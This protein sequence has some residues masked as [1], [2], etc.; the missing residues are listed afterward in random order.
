MDKGYNSLVDDVIKNAQRL[1]ASAM[2]LM[3]SFTLAQDGDTSE[4]DTKETAR[5]MQTQLEIE[6]ILCKQFY[7][8]LTDLEKERNA[9][10]FENYTLEE[11]QELYRKREAYT[12]KTS[13]R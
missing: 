9:L 2:G 8:Y 10:L 7:A 13:H 12:E 6:E 4:N 11:L 3:L 5:Q 1:S